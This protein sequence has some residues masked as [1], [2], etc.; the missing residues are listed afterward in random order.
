MVVT[1]SEPQ[2]R[3]LG[4]AARQSA[5]EALD[6]LDTAPEP[7]FE[8]M[9]DVACAL[10]EAPIAVVTFIDGRRQWFKARRG[11][12]VTETARS[13]AFCAVVV[14][15][16]ERLVVGDA[17]ADNRFAVNPL[18]VGGPKIRFYAGVPLVLSS[19]ARVG[20]L[21][22]MDR[23]PRTVDAAAVDTLLRLA[24]IVVDALEQRL[25]AGLARKEAEL[26]RERVEVEARRQ[27]AILHGA[28]DAIVLADSDGR[29][30]EVNPAA[31][32]I[33]GL[34][35]SVAIGTKVTDAIV[36]PAQRAE[37]DDAFERYLATGVSDILGRQLEL[38][39]V[40]A[41]GREFPVELTV[42][43]LPEEPP[44]FAAF[45]RDLTERHSL[46]AQ[47]LHA[48]KIEAV[49]RLAG[50]IAHDFNNLLTVILS[51]TDLLLGEMLPGDTHRGDVDEISKAAQ[52]AAA[53]T[54]QLLAFG[55][56]QRLDRKVLV[57]DD[58]LR[59]IGA[60]I[61]RVVGPTVS[62]AWK[63]D[64]PLLTVNADPGSL[65]QVVMNLAINARDAMPDGGVLTV[66]TSRVQL[67]EPSQPSLPA[68]AYVR[69]ST[70]DSGAGMSP[71]TL[72]RI[73]EPFFTTK[74][75]KGTGLGLAMVLGIVEQ[76]GGA[77]CV[78][79]T[80]G[81]GSTFAVYLPVVAESTRSATAYPP[82]S[83]PARGTETIL[84]VEDE[85]AIRLVAATIL[86]RLGYA[87]LVAADAA[88]ALG[89][90]ART[91]TPI[92][93]LLTDVVMPNM[94]GVELAE[95]LVVARPGLKVLCMSGFMEEGIVRRVTDHGYGFL[96]KPFN[97]ERLI[98][99]VREVLDDALAS[100]G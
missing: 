76:S 91:T 93:L 55:R 44:M 81:S 27:K 57:L 12:E 88:D 40:N 60:M 63:L 21:A 75:T 31:E 78:D 74:E 22:I 70:T 98:L 8:A 50:G 29:I 41:E 3:R 26:T 58:L 43:R 5:V 9:V 1:T 11:L 39:A 97:S 15:T 14:D 68:G 99:R 72:A 42:V 4:E 47:L 62:L 6:I 73:F 33:F 25:R 20:S 24:R 19:G 23:A 64:A 54:Q 10:L 51:Y 82:T 92:D 48:Q 17:L 100:A 79:S 77:V 61:E 13:V 7:V 71:A 69:L 37:Y 87:V 85:D 2:G 67:T 86:R 89:L 45:V 83:Q 28:L 30:V 80:I 46:Q 94:S 90:S 59:N 96:Q 52:R 66:A 16:G 35:R 53:L 65:E 38:S 18:V 95:R 32:R 34:E 49:G 84:L 56:K 36:P